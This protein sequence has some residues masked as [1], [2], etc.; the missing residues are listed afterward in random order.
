MINLENYE[1]EDRTLKM[2]GNLSFRLTENLEELKI[3][4]E[5]NQGFLW[6]IELIL[7]LEGWNNYFGNKPE[8]E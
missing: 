3:I 8:N 5:T 7:D 2:R 1:M 4:F 6:H